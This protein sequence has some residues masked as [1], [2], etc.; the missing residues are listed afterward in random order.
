MGRAEYDGVTI[1]SKSSIEIQF[2]YDGQRRR[3]RIKVKPTKQNLER[4]RIF[5]ADILDSIARGT[6]DYAA[7]FPNSKFAK[8]TDN[9]LTVK[10][11]LNQWHEREKEYIATSTWHEYR[12]TLDGQLIP[13]LGAVLLSEL[14]LREI[15][16]FAAG[17]RATSKTIQNYLSPLRVALDQA[18]NSGLIPTNPMTGWKLRQ[19]KRRKT[20]LD[21]D[22]SEVHPFTVE[23][24][25]AILSACFERDAPFFKFCFWTGMIASELIALKWEDIDFNENVIKV[26]K[27]VTEHAEGPEPPKTKFR[28]RKIRIL[29]HAKEALEEQLSYN[30]KQPEIWIDHRHEV[31][32][33]SNKAI[34][35][36]WRGTLRRAGIGYRKPYQTRH[37]YASMMLS[38]GENPMWVANQMGHSDVNMIFRVYGKWIPK[39]DTPGALAEKEF[40]YD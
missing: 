34:R 1:A 12:R 33:K 32:W 31:V 24:Q 17:H 22:E 35:D 28:I 37:T 30:Y 16:S 27:G 4:A 5:R 38:A 36:V 14:T 10:D 15:T 6:F 8:Q 25:K 29:K 7:T 11:Y 9:G 23:Q 26:Y 40:D 18:V 13:A 19:K 2:Q 3:E 21:P 39:N 20:E